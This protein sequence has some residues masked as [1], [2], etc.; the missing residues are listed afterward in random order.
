MIM[1]WRDMD[2]LKRFAGEDWQTAVIHPDG[3]DLLHETFL[4]HYVTHVE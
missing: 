1:H 4:H 3:A 2:G